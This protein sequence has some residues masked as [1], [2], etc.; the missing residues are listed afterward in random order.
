LAGTEQQVILMP[1]VVL[2]LRLY[3]FGHLPKT[4]QESGLKR[5]PVVAGPCSIYGCLE[6]LVLCQ[7]KPQR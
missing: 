4:G 6:P 7:P 2:E 3:L 1:R 5:R